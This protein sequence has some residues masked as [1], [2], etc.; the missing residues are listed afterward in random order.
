MKILYDPQIFNLQIF[1]GIS[2]YY[3]KLLEEFYKETDINFKLPLIYSDNK[4]LKNLQ[5]INAFSLNGRNIPFK[6]QSI[7]LLNA[8]NRNKTIK[9]LIDQ[10]FDIYHPTY[11]DDYFLNYIKN[12]PYILTVHDM[13][14]EVLPEYFVFDKKAD[15]TIKIKNRLIEKANRIIA[16]S[17]NTKNDIIKFCEIDEDKIDVIY[18]G[19][20]FESLEKQ[21]KKYDLPERYILFVGQRSKYKN[22][23]N[24]L[25]SISNI[26]NEDESLYLVSAGGNP[27]TEEEKD[28]IDSLKLTNKIIY[29]PIDKEESL[30]T[31]YKNA[32]CFVFPSLYE[33]FGFPILEAFQCDCP[34]LSSNTSSFPEIA[35]NAAIYIDPYSNESMEEGT[36]KLIYN[37]TLRQELIIRGREQLKRFSWKET[38][39]L[40]KQS[41]IKVLQ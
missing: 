33:G 34:L 17:E 26:L 5:F 36:K 13:T 2:L 28:L 21:M 37:E 30:I 22:F 12:K 23:I 14:N 18:H 8:I 3:K 20:P 27:F 10:D 7:K 35:Q 19:L 9:E 16:I 25:L 40:T 32:L 39:E 29:K 24:Y 6:K 4:Y 11:F 15:E 41:Y 1:G 31:F 38:A